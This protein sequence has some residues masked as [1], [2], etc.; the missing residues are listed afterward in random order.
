M[1]YNKRNTGDDLNGDGYET[2]QTCFLLS[3]EKNLV[4]KMRRLSAG[5]EI[6]KA[7]ADC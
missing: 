7:A 2:W 4:Y 5:G 1:K 6:N 3:K